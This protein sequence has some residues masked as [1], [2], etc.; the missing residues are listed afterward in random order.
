MDG[1]D[2]V[3]IS[4]A[5]FVWASGTYGPAAAPKTL[6]WSATV[7]PSVGTEALKAW[8]RRNNNLQL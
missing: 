8:G 7:G 1:M 5:S 4:Y 3:L 6:R 2:Y